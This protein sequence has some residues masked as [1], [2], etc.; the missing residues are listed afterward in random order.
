MR[1]P[2]T[3]LRVLKHPRWGRQHV[4]VHLLLQLEL[5][6]CSLNDCEH[7]SGLVPICANGRGDVVFDV[8]R[9]LCLLELRVG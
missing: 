5:A 8:P 2:W 7:P 1:L 3:R 6:D 4:R 9:L